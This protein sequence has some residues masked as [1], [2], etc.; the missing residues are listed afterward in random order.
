[1]RRRA[2]ST[3]LLLVAAG[4]AD[5][6]DYTLYTC[7]VTSK[8]YVV[9]RQTAAERHLPQTAGRRLGA[10]RLQPPVHQ[11]P[12]LRSARPRHVVYVAAGNGLL[13]VSRARRAVEDPDRKR[14]HR[15]DGCRGRP[16]RPGDI[17]FT[18][19]RGHPRQPRPRRHL[20]RRRAPAC[21]GNTRRPFASIRARA[22]VLVAGNEE[23]LFRSEDGG[24]SWRCAGAA[25]FQVLRVEQS[26]HD[27]CYWL[28]GTQGGG[29]FVSTD[30]GVTFEK[31]RQPRR[32]PQ[33]LRHRLRSQLRP[34][35]LQSRDGAS[36][37]P[38]PRISERRGSSATPVCPAPPSGASRSI[39]RSPAG[40]TPACTRKRCTSPHDTADLAKDGLEGSRVYRMRFVP[41]GRRDEARCRCAA[42]VGSL[43]LARRRPPFH[44]RVAVRHRRVR[45]SEEPGTAGYA[46]IAAKLHL[47]E[48][49]A[50]VLAPPRGTARR[51]TGD[52]FWMFP[53]TA[54][55]YLD[56]GQLDRFGAA[57]AAPLLQDLHAVSRRH[58]K[59]LA[60]VLRLALPDGADCGRTNRATSGT[61]ANRRRRTFAKPAEWIESWVRL[62]TTRGQG[63]YD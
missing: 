47:H 2:I 45:A 5:A 60:A 3:V 62:T 48:D 30:C 22:G 16:Q 19:H 11:R 39:R 13:R 14:C 24:E 25:G 34:S 17:Y 58:R 29:L 50:L 10:R 41:E 57:G 52:M 61:P 32:R 15:A 27:P 53:V 18:P 33:H 63:E 28:A 4:L 1:M 40:S 46:N 38:S 43:P 23:G 12:R 55:A 37:W 51:P 9:G 36:A 49:A 6:A 8:D 26:P 42:A 20:E 35:A 44:E 54:V 59:S 56:R 7:M 31:R 21:T